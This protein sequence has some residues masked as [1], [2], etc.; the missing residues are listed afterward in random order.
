MAP[1]AC[2]R[3]NGRPQPTLVSK[4]TCQNLDPKGGFER[5]RGIQ[6]G[7]AYEP[8]FGAEGAGRGIGVITHARPA[9]LL[10]QVSR[11]RVLEAGNLDEGIAKRVVGASSTARAISSYSSGIFRSQS[12]PR[13]EGPHSAVGGRTWSV[14]YTDR[15]N[16]GSSCHCLD[17]NLFPH[18]STL[19]RA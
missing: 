7:G 19:V 6:F 12:V 8:L 13:I 3:L 4:M 15:V 2:E 17:G 1:L 5:A 14:A 18:F 11:L 10:S 9:I 16:N